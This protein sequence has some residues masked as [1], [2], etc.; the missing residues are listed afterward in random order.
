MKIFLFSDLHYSFKLPEGNPEA[1]FLLGDIE[2]SLIQKIDK[3]YTCPKFGVLGNHDFHNEMNG[4]SVVSLHESVIEFN[5]VKM[6]GFGGSPRYNTRPH[7]QYWDDE[8]E[9]FTESLESVDLFLA[10]SNPAWGKNE[11][12]SDP[13]R[14]FPPFARYILNKK[15]RYFFHG[16]LH[17]PSR[18]TV[19]NTE[20]ICV[21]PFLEITFEK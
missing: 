8:V 12:I 15:P 10:H 1:V 11:D 2:Q 19:G 17:E 21:Y 18:R 5:G 16:H 14:G 4:S 3:T 6:A 13:H 7:N 20:L 9:A